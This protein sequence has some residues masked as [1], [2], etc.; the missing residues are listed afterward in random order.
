M[1]EYF[2]VESFKFCDSL[3]CL[4][5]QCLVAITISA[6]TADQLSQSYAI[7]SEITPTLYLPEQR[8]HRPITSQYPLETIICTHSTHKQCA[9]G[10]FF[11]RLLLWQLLL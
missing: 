7:T 11:L 8:T 3:Q 9:I 6:S 4:R 10:K 1:L 5:R 2:Q